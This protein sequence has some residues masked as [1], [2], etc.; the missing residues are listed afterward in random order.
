MGAASACEKPKI[1]LSV[2]AE[3]TVHDLLELFVGHSAAFLLVDPLE[4]VVQVRL[5]PLLAQTPQQVY[6]VLGVEVALVVSVHLPEHPFQLGLRLLLGG[7]P[8]DYGH[9]GVEGD[10]S[11]AVLVVLRDDVVDG[12]LGGLEAIVEKGHFEV[13]G[14]Q[15]SC[16]VGVVGVEGFLDCQDVFL[17]ELGAQIEA[18][19]ELWLLLPDADH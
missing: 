5:L 17:C 15:Q 6:E 4:D 12:F 7:F 16:L 14:G 10:S 8:R 2:H 3:G 19:V 9:E 18:G 13:V 11:E 1:N